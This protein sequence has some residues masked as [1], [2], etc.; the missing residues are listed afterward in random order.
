MN[1][2]NARFP[3]A[4]LEAR[5]GESPTRVIAAQLGVTARTV[6][7]WRR[8]GLT[9]RQA[10]RAAI[11]AGWHPGAIWDTWWTTNPTTTDLLDPPAEPTTAATGA[12]R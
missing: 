8:T 7:R 11:A 10:D 6:W 1:A 2:A 5:L 3:F 9:D 12:T 4:D